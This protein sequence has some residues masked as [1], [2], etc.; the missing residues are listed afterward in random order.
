MS[1]FGAANWYDRHGLLDDKQIGQLQ[2]AKSH[3]GRSGRTVTPERVVSSLGFGFWVTL[4]SR[5]YE[6]RMWR[7]NRSRNIKAAFPHIPKRQR[8]RQIIHAQCNNLLSLRNLAFH[9]EPIFDR[10]TLLADHAAIYVAIGWI[11]P[12]MVPL[13]QLFDH[14]LDTH[15]HGRAIT[16]ATLEAHVGMSAL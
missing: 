5:P 7:A 2:S 16:E 15:T 12:A 6:A 3:I 13:T 9:H 1:H 11:D 14:F 10:P 4:L 8:Q